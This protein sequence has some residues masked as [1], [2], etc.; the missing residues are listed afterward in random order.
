MSLLDT[1]NDMK[2]GRRRWWG[3]GWKV[4]VIVR[5]GLWDH[6][7]ITLF[8]PL[9]VSD[10]WVGSHWACRVSSPSKESLGGGHQWK[11]TRVGHADASADAHHPHIVQKMSSHFLPINC[12]FGS[13]FP[14]PWAQSTCYQYELEW[15]IDLV[16][17]FPRHPL[18]FLLQ[19]YLQCIN[20]FSTNNVFLNS[21]GT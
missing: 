16:K 2:W 20:T 17:Q 1:P 21:H 4:C 11:C 10:T 19:D 7:N 3:V 13:V 9:R 14:N 12:H 6:I 18:F 5:F 15:R 8:T